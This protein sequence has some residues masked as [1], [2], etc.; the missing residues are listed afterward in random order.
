M[1]QRG[2]DGSPSLRQDQFVGVVGGKILNREHLDNLVRAL[3]GNVSG[4]G[5]AEGGG[6]RISVT[7]FF[8]EH[9]IC[10]QRIFVRQ[11]RTNKKRSDKAITAATNGD[12]PSRICPPLR[13]ERVAG[14]GIPHDV[15][16]RDD[17]RGRQTC[18]ECSPSL[19]R[20]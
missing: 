5:K 8:Q 4:G 9:V 18:T 1:S 13:A 6:L 2:G 15:A 16:A 10:L 11:G 19:R 3:S 20:L 14:E 17:S 7:I 12:D